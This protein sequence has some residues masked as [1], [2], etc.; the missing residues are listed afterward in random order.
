MENNSMLDSSFAKEYLKWL[1]KQE[2]AKN[3]GFNK[4]DQ[5]YYPYKAVERKDDPKDDSFAP[6]KYDIGFGIKIQS[7]SDYERYSKGLTPE[8]TEDLMAEKVLMHYN[9]AEKWVEEKYPGKWATLP[10]EAK[11]MLTDYNFNVG[12]IGKFPNMVDGIVM[13]NLNKVIKEYERKFNTKPLKERNNA[14]YKFFILRLEKNLDWRSR[15]QTIE[16][17]INLLRK[18]ISH[19]FSSN[20]F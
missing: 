14:T 13:G 4:E 17:S 20:L 5:K 3:T 15:F 11:F 12:T 7:K 6:G 2:N 10:E 16:Q 1:M 18:N 8:E 9:L 19:Q